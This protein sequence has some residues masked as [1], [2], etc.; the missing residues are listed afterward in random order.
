[1]IPKQV[2]VALGAMWDY[3][4]ITINTEYETAAGLV[5]SGKSNP[6]KSR[7]EIIEW[8][9]QEMGSMG[10]ELVS[11]LPALP[12]ASPDWEESMGNPWMYH[13]IFKRP[14]GIDK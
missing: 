10:W 5:A 2:N 14:K 4:V 7:S 13:A 3:C 6:S 8:R 1:M 12:M 9:L 11:F